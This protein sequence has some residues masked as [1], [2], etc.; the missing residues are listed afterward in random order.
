M[1]VLPLSYSE[2]QSTEC[3]LFLSDDNEGN[4]DSKLPKA[5]KTKATLRRTELLREVADGC[6]TIHAYCSA[7]VAALCQMEFGNHVTRSRVM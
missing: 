7:M 6:V 3:G 1:A 4:E 5:E 2:T